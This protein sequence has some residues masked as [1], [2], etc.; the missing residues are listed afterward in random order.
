MLKSPLIWRARH[1]GATAADLWLEAHR[2]AVEMH[3]HVQAWQYAEQHWPPMRPDFSVRLA[4]GRVSA[5]PERPA[6]AEQ[7]FKWCLDRKPDDR[8]L[9]AALETATK[10]RINAQTQ[11]SAAGSRRPHDSRQ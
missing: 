2:L 6:E 5:R 7:H 11:A 10:G 1:R 3:D 9:R 4:V 8:Q